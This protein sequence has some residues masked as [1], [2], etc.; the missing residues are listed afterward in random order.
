MAALI[1]T[2]TFQNVAEADEIGINVS[3]RVDQRMTHAGLSGE[4][5]D[6]RKTV[7][8]KERSHAGAIGEIEL[9]EAEA[10]KLGQFRKP[11]VFQLRIVIGIQV[12]DADDRPGALQQTARDVKA[13]E[14]G[15]PGD[16]NGSYSRHRSIPS[17]L[18]FRSSRHLTSTTVPLPSFSKRAIKDQPSLT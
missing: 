4:M 5:H 14:T 10:R 11:R 8:G 3:L 9:D 18:L 7:F 6:V 15:G 1:V 12:V 2:A 16:K 17:G 13:D